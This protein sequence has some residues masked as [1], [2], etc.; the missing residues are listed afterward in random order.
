VEHPNDAPYQ[1]HKR[2]PLTAFLIILNALVLPAFMLWTVLGV[3]SPF[4]II[5]IPGILIFG[6]ISGIWEWIWVILNRRFRLNKII[7]F[8]GFFLPVICV[9]L[10]SYLSVS[11]TPAVNQ[12]QPAV[13]RTGTYKAYV[14]SNLIGGRTIEIKN[15]NGSTLY[16][17]ETDFAPNLS[18]YWIWGPNERL[19]LYNSDDDSVYVWKEQTDGKWHHVFWGYGHNKETQLELGSPPTELYPDY[20]S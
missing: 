19:W 5:A 18:M 10:S 12:Q 20:G 17:E 2:K 7:W 14:H 11:H 16:N 1:S 4:S 8:I 6:A 9:F 15:R 13:S 3:V